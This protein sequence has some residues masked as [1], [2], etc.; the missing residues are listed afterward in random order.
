MRPLLLGG[1]LVLNLI[2]GAMTASA[3][4]GAGADGALVFERRRPRLLLSAAD[5]ERCRVR[6][7]M[8]VGATS[9]PSELGAH[10]E[11]YRGLCEWAKRNEELPLEDGALYIPAFLHLMQPAADRPDAYTRMIERELFRR[12]F[13]VDYDD[14]IAALDWCWDALTPAVRSNVAARL[15]ENPQPL[16]EIDTPFEHYL[17]APK[18]NHIAAAIA[19]RG[20]FPPGTLEAQR[21]ELVLAAAE[22]YFRDSLPAYIRLLHGRAAAPAQA[23]EYEADLIYALELWDRYKQGAYWPQFAEIMRDACDGYLWI[24]TQWRDFRSVLMHDQGSSAPVRPGE[25]TSALARGAAITLARRTGSR[26]AAWY[27]SLETEV[28]DATDVGRL[29]QR[30]LA[31]VH[32]SRTGKVIDPPEPGPSRNLGNGW[33]LMRSAWRPGATVIGFDAGQPVVHGRQHA[34]AGQFQILRR[35]RLALDSGDD[36]SVEAVPSRGG[37]QGLGP[38]AGEFEQFAAATVAHNCMLL[39]DPRD[40]LRAVNENRP[41]LG[42]QRS[43]RG[44]WRPG[45]AADTARRQSGRL[46]AYESNEHYCYAAADLAKAYES[47]ALLLYD[48][49]LL[50]VGGRFLF[51]VDRLV[52]ERADVAPTWLLQLPSRPRIGDA[53]LDPQF[54]RLGSDDRA[55]VW[56][57]TQ[58]DDWLTADGGEGR[59]FV[60]SILPAERSWAIVGG[61]QEVSQIR[62]GP[63]AGRRYVGSRPNGF[64]YRLTP[65]SVAEG[66]NAWYELAQPGGLGP[67][68]GAGACWGRLEVEPLN[69]ATQHTFVHL[70]VPDDIATK[71]PPLADVRVSGDD[72][73]F[74][75]TVA[76]LTYEVSLTPGG[77]TTG[78]VVVR[79]RVQTLMDRGLTREVQQDAPLLLREPY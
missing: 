72:V 12:P 37:K 56:K 79:D 64:E 2:G 47:K 58:Q 9:A 63:S 49:H 71:S 43:F 36:V 59:L 18:L 39:I 53:D 62:G 76:D 44:D 22:R 30:W 42:G 40:R 3:Q 13:V 69:A 4:P 24:D 73:Q 32:R 5:V 68:F 57:Y 45:D 46:L 28:G 7:G 65:A 15:L 54:R 31:I 21:V 29:N 67:M 78:K 50:F 19:L 25:G 23:A 51:V 38:Q 33:V 27:A 35:G 17:F 66:L 77:A 74:S 6:C 70:L 1:S 60:R 8:A 75:A 10:A 20:E 26:V 52:T 55:G 61:P 41:S 14:A 16:S 48:R 11:A 34:D